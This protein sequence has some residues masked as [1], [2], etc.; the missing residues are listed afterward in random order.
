MAEE[1]VRHLIR[2]LDET[3]F[4]ADLRVERKGGLGLVQIFRA[5]EHLARGVIA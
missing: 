4:Q 5:D 2:D 3:A 1:I